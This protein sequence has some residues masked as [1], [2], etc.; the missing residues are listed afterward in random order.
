MKWKV[1]FSW[2]TNTGTQ[3][4]QTSPDPEVPWS[5]PNLANSLGESSIKNT[6]MCSWKVTTP[7]S[8]LPSNTPRSPNCFHSQAEPR[9]HWN[10]RSCPAAEGLRCC[11][12]CC[13]VFTQAI[14]FKCFTQGQLHRP[15]GGNTLMQRWCGC[16][17]DQPAACYTPPLMHSVSLHR[18]A[19]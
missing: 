4:T 18:G 15:L 14:A 1:I 17:E 13:R 2:Q 6:L 19:D 12:P 7:I 9:T 16:Q 5:E 11:L 3:K 10:L 8:T